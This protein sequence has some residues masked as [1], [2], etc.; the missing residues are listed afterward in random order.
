MKAPLRTAD[1]QMLKR[2]RKYEINKGMLLFNGAGILVV[3][4]LVGHTVASY[5]H[6]DVTPVCS[7]RYPAR[8]E[9][10]FEAPNGEPLSAIELQ[11]RAGM[12][13]WG[14]LENASTVK[15]AGAPAASVLEVKLAAAPNTAPEGSN[16]VGLGMSWIPHG[17]SEE[18]SG[19]LT[20]SIYMP[21]NF[22][23]AS[24]GT[25]PG[26][27]G[28]AR[29]ETLR[30]NVSTPEPAFYSRPVWT[31]DGSLELANR[32]TDAGGTNGHNIGPATHDRA[33]LPRGQWVRLEQEVVMNTPGQEDGISRLWV[34]G[35]LRI[36]NLNIVWHK[37]TV[38]HVSGV[39][40]DVT[41]PGNAKFST[42]RISPPVMGWK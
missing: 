17:I 30:G 2:E 23:F 1:R 6:V 7:A 37:E 35:K 21:E 14:V 9:L 18:R 19:C 33:P 28:G 11:S 40:L 8:M 34:D 31:A 12:G 29:P 42:L 38:P 27:Y 25:L 41:A 22:D 20:Y 4:V 5:L 10:A 36:E 24:T 15:A 39:L 26:L 16:V 13:E 32:M 3:L